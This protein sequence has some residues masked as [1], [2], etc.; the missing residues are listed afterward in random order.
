LYS[1]SSLLFFFFLALLG[2]DFKTLAEL[3]D[4]P[5]L[6]FE[7]ELSRPMPPSLP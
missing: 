2:L 1:H 4:D 5:S 3:A 6:A 7:A